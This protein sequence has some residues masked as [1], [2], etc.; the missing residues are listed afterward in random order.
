ESLC[1]KRT[2]ADSAPRCI[3]LCEIC[4]LAP[5]GQLEANMSTRHDGPLALAQALIRCP[6]VTPEEGGALTWL[7]TELE[8][9]GFVCHR[10][11]MRDADTPDVDNLYARL[12]AGSPHPT[13][14]CHTDVGP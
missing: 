2:F 9:L 13:F 3:S 12:G 5:S 4:G 14:A 6:S 7:A 1:R 11:T 10:L 8:P